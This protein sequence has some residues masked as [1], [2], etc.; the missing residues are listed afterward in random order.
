MW[1]EIYRNKS[2]G[3]FDSSKSFDVKKG[4]PPV[5]QGALSLFFYAAVDS[6]AVSASLPES[7]PVISAGS[8]I[9]R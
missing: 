2:A 1:A 9:S 6:W 7:L 5:F 8:S 4:R 3:K